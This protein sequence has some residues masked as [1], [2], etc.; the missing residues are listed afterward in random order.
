ME[1]NFRLGGDERPIELDRSGIT[2]IAPGLRGNGVWRDVR[3]AGETR[4]ATGE[5]TLLDQALAEANLEDRHTIELEADTPSAAPGARGRGAAALRD[6]E[7]LLDVPS[8]RDEIQFLL[9]RDEGGVISLH[10]PEPVPPG[11]AVSTRA[12]TAPELFRYRLSLRSATARGPAV[13]RGLFGPL[14]K[15]ILKVVVLKLLRPVV[16]RAVCGAATLWEDAARSF[17]GFHGGPLEQLLGAEP[18]PFGD[19]SALQGKKALL[20]LHG[21]TSTT[22]G[23]FAGLG[24]QPAAA[25]RLYAAYGDRVVGFNHHT[26]SRSVS[27]NAAELYAALAA[28]PGEYRFDVVSHSRGG[29]LARA[30]AEQAPPAGMLSRGLAVHV[31]RAV[32]VGTPNSGTDL[33]SP[34]N[35]PKTLDR[36]ANVVSFLPDSAV[37]VALSGVLATAAYVSEV[38]L[39]YVPGLADQ[40]PG[41]PFLSTLNTPS[42]SGAAYFAI[43]ANYEPQ[44]GLVNAIKDGVMDRLFGQTANDLVVPTAGVSRTAAFSLPAARVKEYDAAAQVHHTN[45]FEQEETW[46]RILEDLGV[47]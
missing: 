2:L 6:D 3:R 34:T 36:L 20:F 29:L 5:K 11:K 9:Y 21:T 44:G 26:L 30:L 37:T 42:A 41:S 14:A 13:G 28:A 39:A 7:V 16:G 40:A 38:G 47:P 43:Q 31:D 23:A 19:W 45:F 4:A 24:T 17:R 10:M 15:K 1:Q 18:L 46:T 12:V 22:A 8:G 25:A 33:A 27:E 32:F 35:L